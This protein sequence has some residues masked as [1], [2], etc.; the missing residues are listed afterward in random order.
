MELPVR[1]GTYFSFGAVEP[2]S[3]TPAALTCENSDTTVIAI[4]EKALKD[5]MDS[6]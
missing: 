5:A 2:A 3:D 1:G 6:K 4:P